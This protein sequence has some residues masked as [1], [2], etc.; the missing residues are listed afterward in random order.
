MVSLLVVEDDPGIRS[1]LVRALAGHGHSVH[2]ESAGLPGL[3]AVIDHAPDLVLLDLDLPDLHGLRV[4]ARLREVSAVP[5]IVVTASDTD[6]SI[7]QALD[8][9][10]DDYVV[11]PFGVDHLEARI[12]AVLRRREPAAAAEPILVG[13]LRVDPRRRIVD[14]DGQ[15]LD[16]TRKEFDLLHLLA[17]RE[18]QVVSKRELMAEVWRLP[19]GGGERTVDVH[20]SWLRRKL[21]ETGEH[22]RYLHTVRGIGV[23]LTP[24]PPDRP[25]DPDPT[26]DSA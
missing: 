11:K 6:A 25:D 14:L 5:V 13:G 18:G 19:Y 22:P 2:C 24:P 23:R 1:A 9:G 15:E 7:V 16:L 21:G 17:C 10:A 12:R 8:S 4:L 20:L 3:Q 26:S